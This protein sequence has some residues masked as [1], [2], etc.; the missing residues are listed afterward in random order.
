VKKGL[1]LSAELLKELEKM[2]GNGLLMGKKKDLLGTE[3]NQRPA[4]RG[5][6]SR[7]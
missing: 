2:Q 7:Y 4:W 5:D 3:K 1:Y 6:N